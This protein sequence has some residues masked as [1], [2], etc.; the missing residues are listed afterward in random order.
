MRNYVQRKWY[1]GRDHRKFTYSNDVDKELVP[2]LDVFNNIPGVRTVYSCCGH[3]YP[4]WYIDFRTTSDF[5][6]RILYKF[7]TKD[8]DGWKGVLPDV[9]FTVNTSDFASFGDAVPEKRITVYCD[10]LGMMKVDE[11]RK[12]YAKICEVFSH[13]APRCE[14]DKVHEF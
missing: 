7:F 3:G 1:K 5:M 11:R 9:D 6:Y 13:Y 12:Q 2:M 14:W 8:G 10:Q 4:G